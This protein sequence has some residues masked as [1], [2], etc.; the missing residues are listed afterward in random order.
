M[1]H[2]DSS[3][4]SFLVSLYFFFGLLCQCCCSSLQQQQQSAVANT[5][6][7]PT[8][9]DEA[10]IN[11]QCKC[12]ENQE[13]RDRTRESEGLAERCFIHCSHFHLSP[14]A[15]MK[16]SPT[17]N[18]F[19]AYIV[20]LYSFII[21]IVIIFYHHASFLFSLFSLSFFRC[22]VVSGFFFSANA[23]AFAEARDNDIAQLQKAKERRHRFV[24][25][26]SPPIHVFFYS[27]PLC[28]FS[29]YNPI[30]FLSCR[31]CF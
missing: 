11:S 9:A 7:I 2:S 1:G 27:S 15:L 31:F 12:V 30:R 20:L 21:T 28:L 16:L 10:A 19:H 3:L 24:C 13:E 18:V 8:A 5:V 29:C 25:L 26:S 14:C 17:H 6:L 22:L 23:K 4:V